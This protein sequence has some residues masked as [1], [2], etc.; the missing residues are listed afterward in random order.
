LGDDKT[1]QVVEDR[2]TAVRRIFDLA[3]AG[4]GA[5]AICKRLNDD[6]VTT[7][8]S[9]RVRGPK[10]KAG[11]ERIWRQSTVKHLLGYRAVVGEY[12]S[13]DG[14]TTVAGY[15]PAVVSEETFHAVQAVR[16]TGCARET[17]RPST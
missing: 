15:W 10:P 16:T 14:L 3:L 12:V 1:W 5:L 4:H 6:G 8:D 2:A 11:G 9:E 13:K 17:L 7:L